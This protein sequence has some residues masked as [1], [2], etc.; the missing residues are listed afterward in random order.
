MEFTFTFG[1]VIGLM[2]GFGVG[3]LLSSVWAWRAMRPHD[4]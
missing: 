3:V 1:L 4:N 2:T